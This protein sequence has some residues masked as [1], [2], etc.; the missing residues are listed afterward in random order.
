[1][2]YYQIAIDGPAGSGKSS[3]AKLLARKLGFTFINSGGFYRAVTV[4]IVENK[5]PFHDVKKIIKLIDKISVTQIGDDMYLNGRKVT[6][7]CY[8]AEI[9]TNVPTIS[10]IKEVREFCLNSK[11]LLSEKNNIV[12]EGRD[13]TTVLFPNAT[14][15]C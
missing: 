7:Q 8:S 10:K 5:I 6:D 1:M 2:K 3:I 9:T 11:V 13:T 14:L 12:I 15:K 4:A